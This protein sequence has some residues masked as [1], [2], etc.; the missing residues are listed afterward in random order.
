MNPHIV[1]LQKFKRGDD[2]D[3]LKFLAEIRTAERVSA[4]IPRFSTE[5][6]NVINTTRDRDGGRNAP[7]FAHTVVCLKYWFNVVVLHNGQ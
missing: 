5:S 3:Y 6:L 4:G 1:Y 2:T 7:R